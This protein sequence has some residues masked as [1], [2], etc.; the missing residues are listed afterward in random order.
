MHTVSIPRMSAPEG[1]QPTVA[2]EDD[3]ACKPPRPVVTALYHAARDYAGQAAGRSV[4]L[5]IFVAAS[6]LAPSAL[7][8]RLVAGSVGALSAGTQAYL[9]A[10]NQIGIESRSQKLGIGVCTVA[11]A[12]A[13]AC[14]AGL[15][16]AQPVMTLAVGTALTVAASLLRL[17]GSDDET[18]S[19]ADGAKAIAFFM[20]TAATLTAVTVTDKHWISTAP[21]LA[22]RT[23][24]TAGESLVVELC[25]SSLERAGLSVNR[26]VLNFRGQVLASVAGTLPYLAATVLLNGYVGALLRGPNDAYRFNEL[27]G[28]LLFGAVANAI[29]G[30]SNAAALYLLHRGGHCIGKPEARSIRASEGLRL[31]DL[32]ALGQKTA[33]RFFLSNCRNAIY[34]KMREHGMSVM[35][36]GCLAQLVYAFFAQNRELI[37]ELMQA[38]G[39]TEPTLAVRS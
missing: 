9:I 21:E 33:I 15:G 34:L 3:V 1:V 5:G 29:R 6:A 32:S 13:G 11:A 2:P 35:Q 4:G 24:G 36:A 23:L 20:G 14:V 38:R 30:A 26:E 31:P 8:M 25:K 12:A 22:A 7:P 16:S 28:P 18:A 27:I 10:R 39:W 19:A 37:F 17:C